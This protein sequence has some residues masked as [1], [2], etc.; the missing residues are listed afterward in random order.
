MSRENVM[1]LYRYFNKSIVSYK[2]NPL[3]KDFIR[4]EI[5]NFTMRNE[6]SVNQELA[7]QHVNVKIENYLKMNQHINNERE[8]L[9]SYG[10]G[11][12]K[13]QREKIENVA[14]YVGLRVKF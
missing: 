10:I 12:T 2:V 13:N 3:Y 4:N 9:E 8:I 14:K 5:D 11:T 7:M 1:K 6:N